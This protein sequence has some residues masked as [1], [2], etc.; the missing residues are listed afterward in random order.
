[1]LNLHL[2][3]SSPTQAVLPEEP[4]R[5]TP[6]SSL[7]PEAFTFTPGQAWADAARQADIAQVLVLLERSPALPAD[8]LVQAAGKALELQP[9]MTAAEW[10]STCRG[11]A[12]SLGSQHAGRSDFTPDQ[13]VLLLR[14]ACQACDPADAM[15]T[16]RDRLVPVCRQ[17]QRDLPER[18]R[19][20]DW[21]AT[22]ALLAMAS[23]LPPSLAAAI[24][25]SMREA[26]RSVCRRPY[27]PAEDPA[28]EPRLLELFAT[29]SETHPGPDLPGVLDA[30]LA[31][32]GFSRSIQL[33]GS[34]PGG[35]ASIWRAQAQGLRPGAG[36]QPEL[37]VIS[38]SPTPGENVIVW[39][40]LHRNLQVAATAD[41][42]GDQVLLSKAFV[43]CWKTT[44]WQ[45]FPQGSPEAAEM[46]RLIERMAQAMVSRGGVNI[47]QLVTICEMLTRLD[48]R[49]I[50]PEA[51]R[52]VVGALYR[53]D[54]SKK[55]AMDH[56]LRE[57]RARVV[58]LVRGVGHLAEPGAMNHL[59]TALMP[60]V[61]SDAQYMRH[62]ILSQNHQRLAHRGLPP[63]LLGPLSQDLTMPLTDQIWDLTAALRSGLAD[64]HP[65]A[66]YLGNLARQ[67]ELL[68][69]PAPGQSS[70]ASYADQLETYAM[71]L[72]ASMCGGGFLSYVGG[73]MLLNVHDSNLN[74]AVAMVDWSLRN[75][76]AHIRHVTVTVGSDT[77][78][79]GGPR[80]SAAVG[81]LARDHG[82]SH[83]RDGRFIRIS[84]PPGDR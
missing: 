70:A 46:S 50:T 78:G 7:N 38:R 24:L 49:D 17:L 32:A 48:A 39:D 37:P 27:G 56:L 18:W 3:A 16:L 20:G 84:R 34:Q 73:N 69:P 58:R 31:A 41:A 64:V 36:A 66:S 74:A 15:A 82:F 44:R 5:E 22:E 10:A 59:L 53:V 83:L 11:L 76:P 63:D 62:S 51:R 65:V 60:L 52:C 35:H 67:L 4:Q 2:T 9:H 71:R 40:E 43:T 30:L 13:L 54:F 80:L 61:T 6:P 75:L 57:F 81:N 42:M 8:R 68:T 72:Q 23:R 19:L 26:T 29:L 33:F 1:M 47:R 12:R 21:S 77:H 45:N 14:V 55:P 28:L 79:G 25:E